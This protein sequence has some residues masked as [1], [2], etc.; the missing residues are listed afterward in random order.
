MKY[1][2][3]YE[4]NIFHGYPP[5]NPFAV[6]NRLIGFFPSVTRKPFNPNP[7]NNLALV[8]G[9]ALAIAII[10]SLPI[11]YTTY[12]NFLISISDNSLALLISNSLVALL[13]KIISNTFVYDISASYSFFY[14]SNSASYSTFKAST[15]NLV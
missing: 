4:Y 9:P 12:L 15:L 14:Y 2:Y 8:S 11:D 6:L 1:V 10:V 5:I 7:D 13:Y 3:L